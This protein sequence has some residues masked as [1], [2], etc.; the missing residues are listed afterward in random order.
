MEKKNEL[1]DIRKLATIAKILD[2]Q[3]IEGADNIEKIFVRGWQCVAKKNE[4][5]VGDLCV[6]I[7]IDAIMPDGLAPEKAEECKAL[8]KEMS[9]SS[10]D[11]D[12][13]MYKERVAEIAKENTRPE[14][15]FLRDKKFHV[16]TRRI[17]GEISQG[18][19]FP[20]SI[21]PIVV[22][23]NFNENVDSFQVKDWND[24]DDV[25]EWLGVT[26]YI[27]PDPATM[28][29]DAKGELQAVGF[30]V[31][32][33]ERCLEENTLIETED[34]I[35]SIKEISNIKYTGKVLSY[36]LE[37]FEKEW[38]NI[39]NHS[40]MKNNNDWF[41]I[42]LENGQRLIT[43]SNHKFYLPELNCFRQLKDLEI[44]QKLLIKKTKI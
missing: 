12:K 24:G 39:S 43:T 37:T 13:A 31:S 28:G 4:F 25:T 5:Q 16:K 21:L 11:L 41:C 32:D 7:E 17:L 1:N 36:N 42:T 29:G 9:R 23:D 20:L 30:L 3:P 14:F 10:S 2:V 35:K 18:I 44:G 33:E 6:Y 15:E 34:G 26:Q 8:L 40:I 19:C 27:P 22:D 38:K